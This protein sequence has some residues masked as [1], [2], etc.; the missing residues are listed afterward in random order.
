MILSEQAVDQ[1]EDERRGRV[2][3]GR[4]RRK[5]RELNSVSRDLEFARVLVA[6]FSSSS[7][8]NTLCTLIGRKG[9][10]N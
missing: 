7:L 8:L 2:V 4:R 10:H 1:E 6:Q 9:G 3:A 5:C